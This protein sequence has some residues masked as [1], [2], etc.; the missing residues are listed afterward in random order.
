MKIQKSLIPLL[1]LL[2][3]VWGFNW[4]VM[5]VA[6][7]YYPA[8]FFVA[9]RFSIGAAALLLVCIARG[10]LLPPKKYWPW[11]GLTGALG[12]ALNM[13]LIQTVFNI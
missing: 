13:L 8:P 10:S 6:N 2:Y 9:S 5:K 12:L 3:A 4:V 1:Q 11:I 7:D